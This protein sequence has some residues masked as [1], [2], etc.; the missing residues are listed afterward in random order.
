MVADPFSSL[1]TFS[2]FSIWVPVIYPIDDCVLP[3]LYLPGTETYIQDSY[4]GPFSKFLLAYAI[5]S[6]FGD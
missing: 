2:S 3:L 1:G 5:V 4:I 6:G